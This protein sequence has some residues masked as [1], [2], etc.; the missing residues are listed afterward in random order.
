MKLFKILKHRLKKRRVTMA[1][2][3]KCVSDRINSSEFRN[4]FNFQ[5][6][7]Q[8]CHI[9]YENKFCNCIRNTHEFGMNFE[10]RTCGVEETRKSISATD[11]NVN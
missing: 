9:E 6:C 11:N 5:L 7:V 4:Y 8:E 3:R 1:F 10:Y 2:V